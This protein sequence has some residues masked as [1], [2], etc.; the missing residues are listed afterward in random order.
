MTPLKPVAMAK[1]AIL[2]LKKHRQQVISILHDMNVVQLEPLSKETDAFLRIERESDLRRNVS[3]QLLR[4]KGLI[5]SLPPVPVSG[6]LRFSSTDELIQKVK[7][8]DIDSNIGTLERQKEKLL[9]KI[10]E[11]ENNIKL[12]EEFSF[13]KEDLKILH[14]SSARSFFGRIDSS[15]FAD[16]KKKLEADGGNDAFLYSKEGNNNKISHFVLVVMSKFPSNALASLVNSFGVHL[17]AVPKLEGRPEVIIQ[18]Q[19]D[20]LNNLTADLAQI[21]QK[22]KKISDENYSFLKAT[23]EQLEIENKN[24]EIVENLGSTRSAFALEGWVPKTKLETITTYLRKFTPGSIM[25]ELETKETPPT[26]LANPK[27]FKVFESFI[28]FY[29]LPSGNEFDP[30]L[31]FGLLFPFFYGLMIGDVGYG[32]VILLVSIWVIRRV[33]GGKRDLNIMPG[34]LRNFAKS[35]LK[36]VQ[37]VKLAKAIIPGAIFTII[38]GFVFNLYFGFHLNE[39]LFLYLNNTFGLNLPEDGSFISPIETFGLRKILLFSGYIG[40]GMVSFGLILGMINSLREGQRKHLISKLGWLLFGWGIAMLG[41]ALINHQDINPTTNVVGL[42]YFALI[43]GGIGLMFYGEGVGAM[44]E[45]PSII[46]HILSFTRI[47][48][49]LLASVILADVI[50]YIFLRTID[51]PLP[52][53]VIGIIILFIGHMFNIILGVFEPGIQAARLIYV[54]FFSKFYH[55]NGKQFKPFG[56]KRKFTYDQCSID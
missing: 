13:F 6:K 22:L 14:L 26:L 24:L 21:N 3:D 7:S 11:T 53:N 15:K 27:R 42:I 51:N 16:F 35:I 36:P 9:T 54:E 45:L 2:G 12:I 19:K 17:E 10:K 47:V 44:M 25:Y 40:L 38:L 50:D 56:S 41:L 4:V 55:G 5:N 32:M 29:S 20:I 18:N 28:R 8:L 39:H 48:G 31:L 1:I 23:E 33:E 49:I 37:M 34:F 52:T 43:F 46:S 30:T